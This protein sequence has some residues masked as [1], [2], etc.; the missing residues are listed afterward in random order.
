ML[1]STGDRSALF[2]GRTYDEKLWD[3]TTVSQLSEEELLC[4]QDFACCAAIPGNGTNKEFA[5]HL[6][7]LCQGDI[8]VSPVC[9][10]HIKISEVWQGDTKI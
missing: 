5:L 1:A 4:Y 6:L 9:Q 2:T 3:P 7:Y 8:K 10:G